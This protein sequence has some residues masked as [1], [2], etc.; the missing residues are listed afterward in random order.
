MESVLE[1]KLLDKKLQNKK[2]RIKSKKQIL[3]LTGE[4]LIEERIKYYFVKE[5][6]CAISINQLEIIN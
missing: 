6:T 5:R 3:T 4:Y 2:C 1:I